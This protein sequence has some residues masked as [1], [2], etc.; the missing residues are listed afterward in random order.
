MKIKIFILFLLTFINLSSQ[1]INGKIVSADTKLPIPFARIGIEKSEYG[2]NSDENG[3]FSIDLSNRDKNQKIKIEVGGYEPY[4]NSIEKF[5]LE[6]NKT[7]FLSEKVVSIEQVVITPKK[8]IA[9]NWGINDKTKKI[10]FSYNP[11]KNQQ[12][13]SK[14][15]ALPFETKKRA[16]IEKINI[17]IAYFEADR[18]VFVRYNVYDENWNS[19]LGEDISILM[20]P[21]D[22]KDS[23]FSLDVS[24][25][26][27][28]V[29]NKFYV[30]FQILSSFKGSIALSG[31]V[32]KPAF[33]RKN[34]GLWEKTP[35][36]CPAL[37]IDV[38]VEK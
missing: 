23:E 7:F 31:T 8:F 2:I 21:K 15:L 33:Y 27:I 5:L 12:D 10:Q 14:E 22:I 1:I 29:K 3:N 37:N 18:P 17:N 13:I 6:N 9:K 35:T 19:I 25:K 16:T 30:S 36:V 38:K 24:D 28:W 32:F 11:E 4:S 20:N 34:L 26:N